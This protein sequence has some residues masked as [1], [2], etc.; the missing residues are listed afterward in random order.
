M[1]E[2]IFNDSSNKNI[3]GANVNED[4]IFTNNVDQNIRDIEH[5]VGLLD[6]IDI[7]SEHK[8]EPLINFTDEDLSDINNHI[9]NLYGDEINSDCI[10][11]L[12]KIIMGKSNDND[13]LEFLKYNLNKNINDTE[14]QQYI[15]M[16][17]SSFNKGLKIAETLVDCFNSPLELNVFD[18]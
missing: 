15:D 11:E 3:F 9:K 6:N 10:N 1:N 4:N 18:I 16:I 5:I 7:D 14:K 8:K 17:I 13:I 2:N 12:F